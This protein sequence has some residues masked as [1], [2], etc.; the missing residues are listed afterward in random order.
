MSIL[1]DL[2]FLIVIM[3]VVEKAALF[4]VK[5]YTNVALGDSV[6]MKDPPMFRP[7]WRIPLYGAYILGGVLS[8]EGVIPSPLSYA[9]IL[10]PIFAIVI[11]DIAS[12]RSQSDHK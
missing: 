10:G 3:L 7:L 1:G 9:L 11:I 8:L 2:A 5:L 4:H 12:L 6:E